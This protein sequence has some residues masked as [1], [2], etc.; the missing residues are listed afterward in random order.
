VNFSIS[1]W[2]AW[3][4][5]LESPE[6]WQ[7][8][9]SAPS[10]LELDGVPDAS[11][12]PAMLRRRCTLLSKIMLKVAFECCDESQHSSV[13]TVFSS[14]HGSINESISLLE[15]VV[16]EERISP[17]IFSHTVHNAQAGL[18]SIAAGN[19]E[20]SSSVAAQ[21]DTFGCG[22]LEAITHLEREP[23]RPVLLVV[24]DVPLSATFG[25]LIDEPACAYGVGLLLDSRRAS[26]GLKI[27]VGGAP[28]DRP[29]LRWPAAAE[30]L[31]FWIS[32][33]PSVEIPTPRHSWIFERG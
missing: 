12:L 1:R 5:G 30:F 24:G 17:A 27:H 19:R 13:R 15:C 16:R 7:R 6:D 28:E 25:S 11:F 18:F 22:L 33:E 31:R 32:G 4:P 2:S 29:A 10:A 26:P 3:A 9:A 21:E 20:A 23:D 14:R 8:W